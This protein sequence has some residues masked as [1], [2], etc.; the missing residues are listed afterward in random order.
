MRRNGWTLMTLLCVA[1]ALVLSPLTDAPKAWAQDDIAAHK[2][3]P[4]CGMDRHK[5]AHSRMLITYDNGNEIGFCSMRCAAVDMANSID[6]APV[7]IQ[8]GDFNTKALID[9]ESAHWVLGGK[10]MGVMTKRAKW[11]FADKADAEA[12]IKANGGELVDFESAM[13]AAYTDLYEDNRM[14]REKRK[15]KR[16]KMKQKS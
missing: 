10:K 16:M 13:K 1:A 2:A 11:A 14:I 4:Y 3:C 12:F 6:S 7:S 15:M 9:A 8:V 5:F